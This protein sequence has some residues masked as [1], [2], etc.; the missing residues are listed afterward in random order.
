[1]FET[2][3]VGPC[4]VQKLKWGRGGGGE[5]MVPLTP[6]WLRPWLNILRNNYEK[7]EKY[8]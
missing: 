1:M 3:T 4:L 2:E 6:Q 5:N 7:L 8:W